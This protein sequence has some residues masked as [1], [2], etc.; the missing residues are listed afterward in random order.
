QRRLRKDDP[1]RGVEVAILL[2]VPFFTERSTR[3]RGDLPRR[4][5]RDARA[6][7]E[8]Q[9]CVALRDLDRARAAGP[10]DVSGQPILPTATVGS[11]I[12]RR[13]STAPQAGPY[14]GKRIALGPARILPHRPF[15]VAHEGTVGSARWVRTRLPAD[16][17]VAL[18]AAEKREMDAP[19]ARG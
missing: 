5:S 3:Q 18:I 15:L 12:L 2:E 10:A 4:H 13:A 14:S 7:P 17:P 9:A 19:L 6:P 1:A 16:F 11:R 8:A